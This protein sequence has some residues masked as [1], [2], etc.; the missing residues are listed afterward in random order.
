MNALSTARAPPVPSHSHPP[1][2]AVPSRPALSWR[3]GSPGSGDDLLPASQGP[4]AGRSRGQGERHETRQRAS[5]RRPAEEEFMMRD[6]VERPASTWPSTRCGPGVRTSSWSGGCIIW[7]GPSG[8][9]GPGGCSSKSSWPAPPAGRCGPIPAARG[10]GPARGPGHRGRRPNDKNL[11]AWPGREAHA[12]RPGPSVSRSRC[13]PAFAARSAR[14][15]D[16]RQAKPSQAKP[17][18]AKPQEHRPGEVT[19]KR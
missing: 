11:A 19:C 3:G 13:G 10:G 14:A 2:A 1:V 5:L 8:G 18:Q 7:A 17:S 6:S 12:A 15:A 9:S 16:R 4:W